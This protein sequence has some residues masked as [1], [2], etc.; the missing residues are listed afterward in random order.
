MSRLDDIGDT[1]DSL[2]TSANAIT[3]RQVQRH[4]CFAVDATDLFTLA[5]IAQ[6]FGTVLRTNPK[7]GSL[8]G[9]AAIQSENQARFFV[10][11]AV[12]CR[13]DAECASVAVQP[14]AEALR[15]R[16]PGVPHQRTIPKDPKCLFAWSRAIVVVVLQIGSLAGQIVL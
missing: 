4:A 15:E 9:P 8:A 13:V 1:S 11:T 3:E 10:R 5:Q 7:R 16:K 6:H 12:M 14:G 2:E